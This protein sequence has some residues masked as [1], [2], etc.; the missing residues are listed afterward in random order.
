LIASVVVMVMALSIAWVWKSNQVKEYYSMMKRLETDKTNMIAEN[1]QLR[2]ALMDMKSITRINEIVT[3]DFG[4]TQNVSQ[5]MFLS[6]PVS[7][8]KV[9]SK[10]NFAVETDIPDWLEN[11]VV[12]SGRVRAETRKNND[13]QAIDK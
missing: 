6:D 9:E 8:E 12:G 11:A 1:T 3:K 10:L 4:L 5:R 13:K 2:A 7:R